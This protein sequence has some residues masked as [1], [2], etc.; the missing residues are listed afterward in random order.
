MVIISA[1]DEKHGDTDTE[2]VLLDLMMIMYVN[3]H[4]RSLSDYSFIHVKK[5]KSVDS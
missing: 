3:I 4:A 2:N 5:G 1:Q